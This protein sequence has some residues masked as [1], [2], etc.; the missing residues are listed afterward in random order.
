MSEENNQEQIELP[1]KK[2]AFILDN[3]V[4]DVLHTEEKLGTIFLSNPIIKDVTKD[5]GGQ[6]AWLDDDYN[7]ETDVFSRDGVEPTLAEA[8]GMPPVKIAFVLNNKVVDILHTDERLGAIF[9]SS[10][11]IKDVTGENGSQTVQ[12]G[13]VYNPEDN[14]F[15]Q[16]AEEYQ[17]PPVDINF[18]GWIYDE[19][20]G[21]SVPPVP[22]PSDGKDYDWSN[23]SLSWVEV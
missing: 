2:I 22:Y 5:G 3:V 15:S 6:T 14:S 23:T 16:P 12:Y 1:A 20:L 17:R 7:A 19:E 13:D 11:I 21:H 18:E 10:P 9:L 8:D 4:V